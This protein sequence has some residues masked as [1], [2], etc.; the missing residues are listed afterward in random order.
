[1]SEPD[2]LV[3][4][5]GLGGVTA[6]LAAAD[7][8]ASVRLVA[9][10]EHPFDDHAGLVDVLGYGGDGRVARPSEAIPSLPAAHPYRRLGPGALEEGLA[11]FD[12]AT[13][14]TYAGS[15][16][17]RNALIPTPIGACRPAARYPGAVE[18]GHCSRSGAM[19]L[20]GFESLP[21]F[22]PGHA[23]G[24]LEAMDVPFEVS[25]AT[26]SLP[27][28]VDESA[29]ALGIARALD[30]NAAVGRG[31]PVRESVARGIRPQLAVVDRVG[32][33]AVLGLEEPA[34][35][36]AA[37]ATELD[38]DVFEVPLGPPS[39]LGRRLE[40]TLYDALAAADVEVDRGADVTDVETGDGRVRAVEVGEGTVEPAAV[41]LAAGG[42]TA[43]GIVADRDGI[44]EPRFGCHVPHPADRDRWTEPDPLGAHRLATFGVRI[45][46]AAR[47]TD[48]D[49]EAAYENLYAAGRVIGGHDAVARH[50]VGGVALATGAAAG[51]AAG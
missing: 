9:P 41:V 43:G 39:V 49:G 4:G 42:P 28:A 44:R 18:P 15:G 37:L 47:P 29:P 1:M 7:E 48:A 34:A 14:G 45:D 2:V 10:R 3:V 22:D 36:H 6:A 30:E 19:A 27:I 11:L 23:A 16:T 21:D 32:L 50:A 33:P 26:L 24:R 13:A 38:A 17:D 8:G 35:V 5:G 12:R 20:V 46:K 31:V 40:R 51:R 25:A